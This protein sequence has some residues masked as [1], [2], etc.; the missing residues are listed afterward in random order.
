MIR[1]GTVIP[2]LRYRDAQ[3]AIKWLCDAFG[4]V[5]RMVVPGDDGAVVH[6]QLGMIMVS[7]CRDTAYDELIKPPAATL[8]L[9]TQSA[10]VIVDDV[11][12]HFERALAAGADVVLPP[13]DEPHGRGYTCRDP[14]GHVWKF[15]DYD[16]WA[17]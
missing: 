9:N 2:T 6:S 16:P 12:S 11:D 5:E 17:G 10:Y 1:A 4:F 3:A 13:T 8:G 7:S 15:G 14:E